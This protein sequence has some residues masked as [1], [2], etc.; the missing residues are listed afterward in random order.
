MN[1]LD[2]KFILDNNLFTKHNVHYFYFKKNLECIFNDGI[3]A[4]SVLYGARG[5]PIMAIQIALYMGYKEIYLLGIDCCCDKDT[6][7]SHFYN[8]EQCTF[9]GIELKNED[10]LASMDRIE[11]EYRAYLGLMNEFRC[12][13]SFAKSKNC[14]IYNASKGG[15]LD[16][17]DRREFDLLFNS[18]TR[19]PNE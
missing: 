16:V 9:R 6:G 18:K 7:A 3:D 10:I 14:M 2:R 13:Q 4:S 8:P 19:I 15:V 12:L 1:Y 5:I 17:F 11:D